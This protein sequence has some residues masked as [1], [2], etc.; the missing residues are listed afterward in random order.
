MVAKWRDVP[1]QDG[2]RFVVTGA[3]SGIGLETAKALAEAGAH[4]VL[5]VRNPDKGKEAAAGMSGD[6]EVA[7]LDVRLPRGMDGYEV[8]RRLRA[9]PGLEAA[10]LV[11]LTGYGGEEERAHAREAGFSAHF[12]KPVDVALLCNLLDRHCARRET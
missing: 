1:R 2:R 4:V 6:L 10:A 5:A 9:Q 11:A 12:V 3:S 8:A 7:L